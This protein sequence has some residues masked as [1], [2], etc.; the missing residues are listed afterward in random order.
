[1]ND[2]VLKFGRPSAQPM[3]DDMVRRWTEWSG[4]VEDAKLLQ[5]AK[6]KLYRNVKMIPERIL[7]APDVRDDFYTQLLDWSFC[8]VVGIALDNRV[9]AWNAKTQESCCLNSHE[10]TSHYYSALSFHPREHTIGFVLSN[11]SLE[12][13]D[14]DTCSLVRTISVSHE[15]VAAIDWHNTVIACGS[16]EGVITLHDT[17]CPRSQIGVIPGAHWEEICGLRWSLCK[18]YIASGGNDNRVHIWDSRYVKGKR[19]DKSVVSLPPGAHRAAVKA[20]AWCPWQRSLLATGGGA[21]CRSIRLTN[22]H[23]NQTVCH[24]KDT[25]S[26]ITGLLWSETHHELLSSHGP[27]KS[28]L[29]LWR[30][31]PT[32]LVR[33][34][35]LVDHS[36]RVIGVARS[37]DGQTVASACSD[38]RLRFWD[39]FA[40][41]EHSAQNEEESEWT[42]FDQLY[43]PGNRSDRKG[44]LFP[45]IR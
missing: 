40:V 36:G 34:C 3:I 20:L 11:G 33:L 9:Y 32:R 25:G 35:E 1:M 38:E 15:R 17:K 14:Y 24:V 19:T 23:R 7:D 37:P 44:S 31:F 30:S 22:V 42:D 26:Q 39:C 43:R 21:S 13:M 41:D 2:N 8:N 16:R 28:Q 6:G 18:Q 29:T 12:L 10:E 27:D 45:N 5:R 4:C